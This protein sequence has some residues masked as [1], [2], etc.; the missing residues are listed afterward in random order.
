MI[1]ARGLCYRYGGAAG[2]AL[3]GVDLEL[4]AG[5]L[6]AILGP[7]G[8]G[9]STLLRVVAGQLAP[10][11]GEILWDGRPPA[12]YAPR[13]CARFLGFLPQRLQP[14]HALRVEEA[15]AL[16]RQMHDDAP[17]LHRAAAHPAVRRALEAA[18]ALELLGRELDQ[19]SGGERQRVLLAAVLV[20]E[21]RVLLLDEPDSGLDL[22]HRVAAFE[23]LL[24]RARQ[25]AAVGIVTH[26]INT[27]AAW[28]DRLVLMR[29]GRVLAAGRQD[30]DLTAE[31]LCDAL[32]ERVQV[33]AHAAHPAPILLPRPRRPEPA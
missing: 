25:G 3:S 16:G 19:L 23:L 24:R 28:A 14:V 17:A 7:N 31:H 29:A 2:D 5:S 12:D 6:T 30:A 9:K 22:G 26:D 8:C 18:D 32:G 13:A 21:S 1:A 27:A 15:V 4:P 11:S 20:Q 10:R 33:L